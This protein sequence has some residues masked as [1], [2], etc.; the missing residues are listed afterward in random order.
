MPGAPRGNPPIVMPP[1]PR[2]VEEI[3]EGI[4]R[5]PARQ[6]EE[7]PRPEWV[8]NPLAEKPVK[9]SGE[10]RAL[11]ILVDFSD[12]PKTT[13]AGFFDQFIFARPG[14]D[15]RSVNSYYDEV[16]YGKV[17][18]VT[19]NKPSSLGW[20]RAPLSSGDY[21]QNGYCIDGTYPNNCQK[22]AEDVI[23][24]VAGQVDFSQY[25]ND[26][27]GVAEPVMIIHSGTGAEFTGRSSDFW[28][29]SWSMAN[30]RKLNG[31]W[32][33]NYILMPEYWWNAS[34][35]SSDITIGVFAHEM[36]HGFWGLPDLYDTD[37]SSAGIGN[38]SLMATGSWNGPGNMG[39]SPAWPDAWSRIQMGF[40][41]PSS[42][43]ERRTRSMTEMVNYLHEQKIS[44]CKL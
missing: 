19:V 17:D 28:S 29:H 31:V 38:W 8:G 11:A 18:F 7:E 25:D 23:D 37:Y 39:S 43:S 24:A 16:S 42:L 20:K 34:H 40:V 6:P 14:K 30:P 41:T 9:L 27:D 1:H 13:K 5:L 21:A 33:S 35:E 4:S 3:R 22:L 10:I 36:G 32:V 2:V 44:K 26:H 12:R 15:G